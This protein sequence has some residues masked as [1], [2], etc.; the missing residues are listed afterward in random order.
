MSK[1]IYEDASIAV[2]EWREGKDGVLIGPPDAG[3]GDAILDYA[4]GQSIIQQA[5]KHTTGGVS[6]IK[7][8]GATQ[9]TKNVSIADKVSQTL[10]A[11]GVSDSSHLVG[12]CQAGWLFARVATEAP[13]Y[14]DSLT[15]AGAPIDTSLG[16]SIL[17]PAF[18]TP[19]YKYQRAVAMFGGV[20]PGWL[21]NVG[22][23]SANPTMHYWDKFVNPTEKTKRF[24]NWY[25]NVQDLAGS[26]Y[27][28][29]IEQVFLE[30]TFKDTLDIKCPVN[31][32]VG[33]K[34]DITPAE[35]TEAIRNYCDGVV[36][37]YAC[38]AGHLGVFT[39]RKSMSMWANIF[40][41][42]EQRA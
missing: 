6:H 17:K 23:K 36:R 22:W 15:V 4:D 41:D 39:A 16:E 14:V 12:L 8:K 20:M 37:N 10:F 13:E 28:E 18:E 34:D 30:N 5:L 40:I 26:W 1:V 24:Y 9:A 42:L 11:M 33:L 21:M 3:H 29:A 19:L 2:I 27:L 32:A 31:I 38:N 25:D 35:Q 7:W